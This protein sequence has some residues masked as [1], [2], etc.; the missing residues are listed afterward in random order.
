MNPVEEDPG[1]K[2]T[3]FHENYFF[4]PFCRL[5]LKKF[6]QIVKDFP[7]AI[8]VGNNEKI[9]APWDWLDLA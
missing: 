3:Y 4:F 5:S 7:A 1:F 8:A 9:A 2:T 6:L